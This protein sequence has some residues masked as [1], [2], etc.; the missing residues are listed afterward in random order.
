MTTRER[1]AQRAKEVADRV[2]DLLHVSPDKR[3]RNE[4]EYLLASHLE[5][6]AARFEGQIEALQ[7]TS[8]HYKNLY[9]S[10]IEA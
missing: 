6:F 10:K 3:D 1:A 4:L 7:T 8:D 9:Y 5:V 2:Q